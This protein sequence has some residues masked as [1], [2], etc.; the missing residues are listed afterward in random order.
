MRRVGLALLLLT[1]IPHIPAADPAPA[2]PAPPGDVHDDSWIQQYYRDPHPER[3]ES[4]VQKMETSGALH[5]NEALPSLAEFFACLFRSAQPAQLTQWL[6]TIDALPEADRR[7]FLIA[8]RWANTTQSQAALQ[9]IATGHGNAA[10][11]ARKL[12]ETPIPAL[13]TLVDPKVS[14]IDMC[15]AAFMATGD[16]IYALVV[17]RCAVRPTKGDVD[18]DTSQEAARWSLKA[19]CETHPKLRLIKDNF[20]QTAGTAERRAMEEIFKP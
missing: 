18:V 17:I 6:K 13:E 2:T 5:S 12:Q 8:L 10:S 20:Y 16:P 7:P 15:W 19:L 3:F 9:A 11:Y 14:E 1:F 4:E